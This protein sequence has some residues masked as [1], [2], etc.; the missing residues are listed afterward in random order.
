MQNA[1][2]K[3]VALGM[4]VSGSLQ[5]S[6]SSNTPGVLVPPPLQSAGWGCLEYD[7]LSDDLQIDDTGIRAT[8]FFAGEEHYTSLPWAA[9]FRLSNDFG[10]MVFPDAEAVESGPLQATGT[11]D[12]R[13]SVSSMRRPRPTWLRLV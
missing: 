2:K 11:E 13:R 1:A 7:V 6:F 3:L 8:L 5:V 10:A 4:V 12:A 9:V